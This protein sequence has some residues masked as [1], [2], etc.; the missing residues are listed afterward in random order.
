[1]VK[2]GYDY[3]RLF[4]RKV[5]IIDKITNEDFGLYQVRERHDGYS[6]YGPMDLPC[7]WSSTIEGLIACTN[8]YIIRDE[9]GVVINDGLNEYADEPKKK[10]QMRVIKD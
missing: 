3:Y 8:D 10:E 2:I 4:M 9:F 1:M 7:F 6:L 5:Y